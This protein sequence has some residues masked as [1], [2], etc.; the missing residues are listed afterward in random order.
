MKI[1]TFMIPYYIRPV[2]TPGN[3]GKEAEFSHWLYQGCCMPDKEQ[4]YSPPSAAVPI[5]L[6]KLCPNQQGLKVFK[7][8]SEPISQLFSGSC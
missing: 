7:I 5:A 4:N 6:R 8:F 1:L 3:I 2:V